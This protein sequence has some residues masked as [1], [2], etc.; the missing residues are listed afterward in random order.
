M[1]TDDTMT[2]EISGWWKYQG[3]SQGD[4]KKHIGFLPALILKE[5]E[6]EIT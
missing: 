1:P 5:K 6:R 2:L 3:R 4:K